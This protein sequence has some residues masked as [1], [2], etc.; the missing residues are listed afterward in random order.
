MCSPN[1]TGTRRAEA[2]PSG[3]DPAEAAEALIVPEGPVLGPQLNVGDHLEHFRCCRRLRA[4]PGL[5]GDPA[6]PAYNLHRHRAAAADLHAHQAL[7]DALLFALGSHGDVHP[8][9][10]LGLALRR[11]G[12]RVTVAANGHFAPLVERVGLDFLPIGTAEEYRTVALNAD[13][14]DP[15]KGFKAV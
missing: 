15:R 2:P 12:H 4:L 10:G 3:P 7:M 1:W 5:R 14:W 13:L 11:R 8:F 9:V 6:R